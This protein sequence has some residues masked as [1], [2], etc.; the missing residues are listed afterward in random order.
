MTDHDALLRA[1]AEH[2][3]EDTPRLMYADWL[4]ENDQPDRAEFVRVQV[5]LGRLD[6]NDPARRP[7]VVR[8]VQFLRDHVPGWKAEL[9]RL[10]GIEWGDFNRGLVEEVQAQT[11]AALVEHAAAVFAEP[12]IHI[13]RLRWLHNAP[14]LAA[15]PELARVRVLRL[16]GAGTYETDLRT[17]LS[18]PHLANLTVLDLHGNRGGDGLARDLARDLCPNLTDLWLGQ[19]GI[20]DEG[21]RALAEA[22]GLRSLR[23]LDLRNNV[24]WDRRVRTALTRRFGSRVKL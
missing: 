20:G 1:I 2:P 22:L 14:R 5:E 11:E 8:H 19:N 15:L 10:P 17:L 12:A 23:F 6:L 16:I 7:W 13:V 9:P 24:I 4:D 3:E 21:G 18:S